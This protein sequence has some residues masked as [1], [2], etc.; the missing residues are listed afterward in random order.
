MQASGDNCMDGVE[1]ENGSSMVAGWD[2]VAVESGS[3]IY[4]LNGFTG[5]A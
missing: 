3:R 5:A 2:W 1:R 4:I